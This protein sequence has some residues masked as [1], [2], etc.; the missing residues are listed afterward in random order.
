MRQRLAVISATLL[1]AG[2]A[3]YWAAPGGTEQAFDAARTRCETEAV[4][5]Y[6]AGGSVSGPAELLAPAPDLCV[7][8]G[9]RRGEVTCMTNGGKGTP[10]A[11]PRSNMS[12][13]A[14]QAFAACMMASGWRPVANADEGDRITRGPGAPRAGG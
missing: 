3:R 5:R 7:A 6:P 2:C 12:E 14:H 1:L 4:S 13:P 11:L 9:G 10:F 8:G